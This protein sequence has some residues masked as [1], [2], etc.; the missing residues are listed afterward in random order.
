MMLMMIVF[1]V[2]SAGLFYASRV[3][4]IRDEIG[5]LLY[6][7]TSSSGEDVGRMAHR[8]FIMF[9]FTSPLLLAGV[10]SLVLGLIR[11]LEKR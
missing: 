2:I 7:E 10:L 3:P 1:A 8:V 9:T 4:A 6:G 11:W 5:M